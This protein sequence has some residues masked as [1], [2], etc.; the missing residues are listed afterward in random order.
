MPFATLNTLDFWRIRVREISA[1][2]W[3]SLDKE[4]PRAA[5]AGQAAS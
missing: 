5:V 2:G 3:P 4:N 1:K